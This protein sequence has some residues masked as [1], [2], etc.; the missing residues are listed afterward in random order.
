MGRHYK[1]IPAPVIDRILE[2][3]AT[4]LSFVNISLETKVN[5]NR[6]HKICS[7]NGHKS[8]KYKPRF[9][10]KRKVDGV[11]VTAVPEHIKKR[12]RHF[13]SK[14]SIVTRAILDDCIMKPFIKSY[15][16]PLLKSR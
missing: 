10:N 11:I 5:P 12:Y 8:L 1:F 9:N 3:R 6:I 16:R 2:L 13:Y 14:K 15:S 7:M 4:G